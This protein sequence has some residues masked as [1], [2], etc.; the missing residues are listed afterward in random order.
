M[1]NNSEWCRGMQ[2]RVTAASHPTAPFYP[3]ADGA[4]GVDNAVMDEWMLQ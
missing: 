2:L 3:A 1:S 4:T